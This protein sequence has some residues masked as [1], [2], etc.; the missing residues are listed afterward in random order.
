MRLSKKQKKVLS[1]FINPKTGKRNIAE[2][3]GNA[4]EIANRATLIF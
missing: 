2:Y 1:F 4:K 3:V